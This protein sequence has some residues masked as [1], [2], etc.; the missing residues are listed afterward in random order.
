MNKI[1]IFCSMLIFSLFVITGGEVQKESAEDLSIP[2]GIGFDIEKA[3]G[4]TI[5]YK[6][7]VSSYIFQEKKTMSR[8]ITGS[9]KSLGQTRQ[10]RQLKMDKK[11]LIG[12]EKVDIISEEQAKEGIR[13]IL[14][15]LFNNPSA[16]DTALVAV[17]SGNAKDI[18][19]HSIKGYPSSSDYIEGMIK[20]SKAFNFFTDNYKTI[21]V[22]VR[23]DAEGRNFTLPYL[24]MTDEGLKIDGVALFKDD[25]MIGKIGIQEAKILNMLSLGSGKGILTIQKNSK[26][27]IDYYAKCKRKVKCTKENEEYNFD[28][29]LKLKGEVI[30]NE[31]DKKVSEDEEERSKLEKEMA[32]KVEESC[33]KLL[34]IMQEEYKVDFLE[35][36][37]IAAA[38]YG[39]DAGVDWNKAVANSN[40]KVKAEV[41]IEK[42]GRGDY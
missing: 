8:V 35:L 37:R 21:D 29:S 31:L 28:I 15:I 18:L 10:N 13:N 23:L 40:I 9:Q 14:D 7:S 2:A 16:N 4:S 5:V 24:V 27:Y 6:V 42:Q 25:K 41:K 33:N 22:F 34:K 39:R 12:L 17:C 20:S 38:R 11:F 3:G 32:E 1:I 36:G 26:E 30:T 19:E